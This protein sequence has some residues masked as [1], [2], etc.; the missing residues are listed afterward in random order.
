MKKYKKLYLETID[1]NWNY[2]IQNLQGQQM[3][4]GVYQ[5][6]VEVAQLPSGIYFLQLQRGG[7]Y[8]KAIKF[9]KK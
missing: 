8:F 1:Q 7:D 6:G 4:N 3:M 9:V 2:T 5:D